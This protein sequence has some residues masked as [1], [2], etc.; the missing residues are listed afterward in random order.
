MYGDCSGLTGGAKLLRAV[1]LQA[2]QLDPG[3]LEAAFQSW[4]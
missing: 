1:L 2:V 4:A 3:K